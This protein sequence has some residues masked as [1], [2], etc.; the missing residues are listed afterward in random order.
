MNE[1]HAGERAPQDVRTRTREAIVGTMELIERNLLP[2]SPPEAAA[3]LD[4][5][6]WS[7]LSHLHNELT[8]WFTA[9]DDIR[10][11]A[12]LPAQLH[13]KSPQTH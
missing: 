3:V 4:D 1:R 5:A 9:A 8:D 12:S 2:V 7:Y 13:A 11:T 10:A 6:A